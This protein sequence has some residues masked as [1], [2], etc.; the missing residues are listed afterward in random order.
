MLRAAFHTLGCRLNQTESAIMAKGLENI[1]Y[2]II[3]ETDKADLCVINTCTV[4]NQSNAKCR[5]RIRTIR[6]KN[7]NAII[8][9][10]GC[11]SQI[12]AEQILEIG[13]VHLIL[14][15]EEKLNLHKYVPLTGIE[16][17][18]VIHIGKIS[19]TPFTIETIGQKLDS[20][21]ANL[22]VQDGCDFFCSFCVIPSARGRSRPREI[23]N[24][25]REAEELAGSGVKELVLTGVNIGTYQYQDI[26][27]IKL[28]DLFESIE[29]I[30]RIRVSSVE[31]TTISEEIF[32]LM[33]NRSSKILPY[34]HLPLQSTS[35]KILKLM[36]RRYIFEEYLDFINQ[37]V[38]E[39]PD[40]CVGSD[41]IT[42]FPGESEEIF[43][44]TLQA[45]ENAPIN[46][47][48]VFPYA[49]RKGTSSEKMGHKIDGSTK[50]R[51]AALLRKLSN[52]KKSDFVQKFNGR[53][54]NILFEKKVD[55]QWQGYSENYIRVAVKSDENLKNR[56]KAV[57]IQKSEE[58]LAYGQLVSC[59]INYATDFGNRKS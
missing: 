1:G 57:R 26:G 52:K 59:P 47:F 37:A 44:E 20:T 6:K 22:K 12:A 56:I 9:V 17:E 13:G 42:G 7:P 58:Q 18:P 32:P 41:I 48:H 36:R 33:E 5:R 46:Y 2:Q 39:V 29:G 38:E 31:P 21:R 8:A 24:I 35:D 15:N 16:N 54:L 45:L 10:V 28:L 19:K 11:F 43:E 14:G 25:R 53:V 55:D 34:L 51:R 3:Q 30:Q 27:F 50:S 40:I 49:E 23:E 4:T